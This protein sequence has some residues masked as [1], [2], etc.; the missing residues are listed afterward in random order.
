MKN[1]VAAMRYDR[2]GGTRLRLSVR[3]LPIAAA[4]ALSACA[5]GERPEP[6]IRT[7]EVRIPVPQPCD[8]A[9]RLGSPAAYPDTDEAL[10]VAETLF[11]QVR[12]LLAGRVLR[13]ARND[14]LEAAVQTCAR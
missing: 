3:V 7:V 8:A 12:L 6:Q 2:R 5:G 9:S 1:D 10:R 14:A 11:D 4:L 13:I